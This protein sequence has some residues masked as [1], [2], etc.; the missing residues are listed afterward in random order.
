MTIR[1]AEGHAL[2]KMLIDRWER[3]GAKLARLADEFPEEKYETFPVA[4]VR[5]FG[6][7]LRHVAF[8]NL[9]V[10]G[11]A[12][13]NKPDDVANELPK[14]TYASK[15]QVIAALKKSAADAAGALREQQAG[16]DPEKAALAESFIE[17][18][19]EHY[20][21]LVVYTRWAGLVPPASR[22]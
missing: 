2:S 11:V 5:T 12:R 7:V 20:G 4:G 3:T 14:A 10:A 22:D 17:H 6:D 16:L 9:Y 21:Q 19:C 18:V 13:G 1:T 15:A 8:W